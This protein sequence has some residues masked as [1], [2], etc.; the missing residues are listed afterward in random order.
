MAEEGETEEGASLKE[1]IFL[2][3]SS[4]HTVLCDYPCHW[5]PGGEIIVCIEVF[6]GGKKT[7]NKPMAMIL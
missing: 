2:Q 7:K 3:A 1:E 6:K 5:V 4:S